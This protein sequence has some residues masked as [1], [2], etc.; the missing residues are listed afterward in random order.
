MVHLRQKME[1][2]GSFVWFPAGRR[3]HLQHS[4]LFVIHLYHLLFPHSLSHG[5]G[6]WDLRQDKTTPRPKVNATSTE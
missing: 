3:S 1:G 6:D 2:T 5:D 4:I